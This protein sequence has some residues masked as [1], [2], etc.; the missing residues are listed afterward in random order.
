MARPRQR[1]QARHQYNRTDRISATVREIVATELERVGDERL[2]MVTVTDV[3]VDQDLATAKV[4]YSAL[5]AE[6]IGRDDEVAEAF[7]DIRWTVQQAVNRGVSAR[8]TPQIS[9]H[10]DAVLKAALRID[11]IVA[12]RIRPAGDLD[13]DLDGD[14]DGDTDGD[15]D[16]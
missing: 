7:D 3:T 11:D 2:E 10:E 8:K 1:A 5:V 4:F 6:E 15:P 13:G 16:R 9:F 12:G 14:T